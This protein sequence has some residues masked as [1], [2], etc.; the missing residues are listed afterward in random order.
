MMRLTNRRAILLAAGTAALAAATGASSAHAYDITGIVEFAEGKTIPEGRIEVYLD[1]KA[2][3]NDARARSSKVQIVSDG[4]MKAV[5]FVLPTD[6]AASDTRQI[7][8]QLLREDGWLLARGSADIISGT[9]VKITLYA[10][11]Y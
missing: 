11:M 9:P 4:G 6:M 5:E 1:D 2:A 3:G 7:V 8:V 10:V